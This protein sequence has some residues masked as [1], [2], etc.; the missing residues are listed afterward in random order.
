MRILQIHCQLKDTESQ[1]KKNQQQ[2][3]LRSI[4]YFSP[5]NKRLNALFRSNRQ[6]SMRSKVS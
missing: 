2:P 3:N 1:Q 5:H 6:Y 4:D